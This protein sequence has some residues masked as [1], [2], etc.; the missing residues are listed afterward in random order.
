M[1]GEVAAIRHGVAGIDRQV[2]QRICSITAAVGINGGGRRAPG[3]KAIST[4][5]PTSR[6]ST[7]W[8]CK[9]EAEAS[10][11]LIHDQMVA[12]FNRG[13]SRASSKVHLSRT[14]EAGV[15]IR[16]YL[17]EGAQRPARSPPATRIRA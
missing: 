11:G 16:R 2:H 5:S 17:E 14:P 6:S 15:V 7:L 4:R 12:S 10:T 3:W 9:P 1:D 8:H 13:L